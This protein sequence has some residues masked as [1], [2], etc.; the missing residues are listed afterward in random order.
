M[1]AISEIRLIIRPV[2]VT[3]K[4]SKT[5][6][7]ISWMDIHPHYFEFSELLVSTSCTS[8]DCDCLCNSSAICGRNKLGMFG[9]K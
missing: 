1:I 5:L 7:E 4:L 8:G 9:P 2:I 6:S 3:L